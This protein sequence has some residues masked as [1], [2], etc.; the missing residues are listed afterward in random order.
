MIT[1]AAQ[2]AG[3]STS[4]G[5]EGYPGINVKPPAAT[6]DLAKFG[7]V[8]LRPDQHRREALQLSLRRDSDA[9]PAHNAWNAEFEPIPPGESRAVRALWVFLRQARLRVNPAKVARVMVYCNKSADERSPHRVA[10]RGRQTRREA[11]R[12]RRGRC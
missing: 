5:K 10:G 2:G 12:T 1:P 7:H 6:W 11:R 3:T 9:D 8:E 4:T